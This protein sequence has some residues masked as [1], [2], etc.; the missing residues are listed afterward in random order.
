[1]FSYSIKRHFEEDFLLERQEQFLEDMQTENSYYQ[2]KRQYI[3][4]CIDVFMSKDQESV[5]KFKETLNDIE[6]EI[7]KFFYQQGFKD[8]MGF[9]NIQPFGRDEK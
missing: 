8:G 1:M 4:S 7:V 9:L 3:S 2:E 5:K 6:S